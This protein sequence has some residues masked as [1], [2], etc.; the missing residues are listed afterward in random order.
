MPYSLEA[1]LA[2]ILPALRASNAR[3]RSSSD[4]CRLD[5]SFFI[6]VSIPNRWARCHNVVDGIPNAAAALVRLI[7]PLRRASRAASIDSGVYIFLVGVSLTAFIDAPPSLPPPA[8]LAVSPLLLPMGPSVVFWPLPLEWCPWCCWCECGWWPCMG[9][10]DGI[11]PKIS[12]VTVNPPPS[13]CPFCWNWDDL[14]PST[15]VIVQCNRIYPFRVVD[16]RYSFTPDGGRVRKFSSTV[17]TRLRFKWSVLLLPWGIATGRC[18][19]ER[20]SVRWVLVKVMLPRTWQMIKCNRTAIASRVA[21][22][23]GCL[24]LW[25]EW[26]RRGVNWSIRCRGICMIA[27]YIASSSSSSR[28]TL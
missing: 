2:D 23:I 1:L 9:M 16:G 22:E 28:I 19:T 5:G 8:P 10:W 12:G 11:N 24:R 7:L 20:V 18:R 3:R 6:G 26:G 13:S 27:P 17:S 15:Q 21:I 4:Q 14:D 25:I